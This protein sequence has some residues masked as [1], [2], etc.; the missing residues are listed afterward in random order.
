MSSLV[1]RYIYAAHSQPRVSHL[2]EHIFV[3]ALFFSISSN[4]GLP[5]GIDRTTQGSAPQRMDT[6]QPYSGDY[7][8][9]IKAPTKAPS[10]HIDDVVGRPR[11]FRDLSLGFFPS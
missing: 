8:T 5:T 3:L 10:A 4:S 7:A 6:Q 2:H 1:T 11:S 9:S